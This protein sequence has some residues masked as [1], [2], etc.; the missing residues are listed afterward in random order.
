MAFHDRRPEAIS[1]EPVEEQEE[2]EEGTPD[3][4]EEVTAPDETPAT[5]VEGE[6]EELVDAPVEDV[7]AAVEQPK[8]KVIS[9][10]VETLEAKKQV[11]LNE[12]L[13]LR[14]EK[15]A[16][17]GVPFQSHQKESKLF[18]PE[19]EENPLEDVSSEDV[20]LIEKVLKAKG[21]V[22]QDDLSKKDYSSGIKN[23]TESWLEKNPEFKPENDPNDENW[24]KL[25]AYATKFFNTPSNPKD[26]LEIL[27]V[28]KERL[29]GKSTAQLPTKS[30]HSV[31]AKKEKIA[32]SAKPSSGGGSASKASSSERG[33]IDTSLL[34][35][36]QGFTDEELKE[37]AAS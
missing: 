27:D 23:F 8:P 13:E 19:K 12:L 10:S 32:I 24:N 18:V 21:Y 6:E 26:V 22:R 3:V 1:D 7:P 2:Q 11:L 14:R 15:R 20:A 30:L 29:F 28:A 17:K 16:E 5:P 34:Q 25:N 9:E 33:S 37:I 36:L 35:H 4:T 31:A